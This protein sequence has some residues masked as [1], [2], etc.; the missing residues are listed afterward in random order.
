MASWNVR[1]F[2]GESAGYVNLGALYEPDGYTFTYDGQ[3]GTLDYGLANACLAR[4]ARGAAIWHI[5]ADEPSVLD[6]N[7]DDGRDPGLFDG[8]TV[9]RASDH[10]PLILGFN[11]ASPSDPDVCRGSAKKSGITYR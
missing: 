1:G 11:L 10:D 4:Q 5:N 6:Y 2:K 7:L 9:F 8:G 3:R